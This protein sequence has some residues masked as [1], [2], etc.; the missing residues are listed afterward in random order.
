MSFWK[1]NK[2]INIQLS[3]YSETTNSIQRGREI[4][5]DDEVIKLNVAFDIKKNAMGEWI[6]LRFNEKIYVIFT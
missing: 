5:S 6:S 3:S 2:N 4:T 1:K